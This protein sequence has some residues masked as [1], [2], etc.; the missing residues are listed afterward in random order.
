MLPYEKLPHVQATKGFSHLAGIRVLDLS[1][2]VAG[3]YATQLLADFGATVLKIEKIEGGDDAR[4]W[5]PPFLNGAS[6]WFLS[7]NR[8][9]HSN[10]CA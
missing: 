9:K 4:Q 5:G 3:P 8:N 10:H 6:L 2:S 1:T 7:V